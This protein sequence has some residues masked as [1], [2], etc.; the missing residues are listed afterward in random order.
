MTIIP[1]HN[2]DFGFICAVVFGVLVFF[3]IIAVI[4]LT[5]VKNSDK[6][7]KLVRVKVRVIKQTVSQGNIAWYTVE[8]EDGER[9]QLRTFHDN[10]LLLQS[11]DTGIIEYRGKTIESFTKI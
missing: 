10:L 7:K 3:G 5:A 4:A 9:I 8:T 6:R 2:T 11:N 1:T